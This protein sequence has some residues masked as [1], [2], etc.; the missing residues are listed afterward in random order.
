MSRIIE[1]IASHDHLRGSLEGISSDGK[2]RYY[3]GVYPRA[4][5]DL[6]SESEGVRSREHLTLTSFSGF[7]FGLEGSPDT[8]YAHHGHHAKEVVFSFIA[9]Q[10]DG[11]YRYEL[12]SPDGIIGNLE[13]DEIEAIAPFFASL[14]HDNPE[15]A[16]ISSE[17]MVDF[18][19]LE[20]LSSRIGLAV[21]QSILEDSIE[22]A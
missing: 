2:I 11:K 5:I 15:N 4:V 1:S 10:G 20:Y 22:V 12:I 17:V 9:T 7:E 21:N 14:F 8:L 13:T 19:V 16:R 18:S 6:P 3:G